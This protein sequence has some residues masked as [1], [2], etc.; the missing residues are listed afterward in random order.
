M[1]GWGANEGDHFFLSFSRYLHCSRGFEIV[2]KYIYIYS[3]VLNLSFKEL[4][5]ENKRIS[6]RIREGKIFQRV[7][8]IS[9]K[10]VRSGYS[11]VEI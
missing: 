3:H 5:E 6:K 11:S 1:E 10:I 2:I 7:T 8:T 4:I 9:Y